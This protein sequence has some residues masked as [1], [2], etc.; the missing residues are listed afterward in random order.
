[1]DRLDTLVGKKFTVAF[2]YRIF[3]EGALASD[4]TCRAAMVEIKKTEKEDIAII[5]QGA[6]LV[7]GEC[8]LKDFCIS[9]DEKNDQESMIYV[10]ESLY[11]KY[12]NAWIKHEHLKEKT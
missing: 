9:T 10:R 1:M 7:L 2:E 8:I 4:V 11:E 5:L 3:E 6:I 12:R